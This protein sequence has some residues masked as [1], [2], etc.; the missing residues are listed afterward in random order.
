MFDLYNYN[1]TVSL[2]FK[3]IQKTV[4][5]KKS[6]K[7]QIKTI[8]KVIGELIC[9]ITGWDKD[10]PAVQAWFTGFLSRPEFKK[11]AE[12]VCKGGDTSVLKASLTK[13]PVPPRAPETPGDNK[14]QQVQKQ[15]S[16]PKEEVSVRNIYYKHSKTRKLHT[17]IS[18]FI[19]QCVFYT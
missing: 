1:L 18:K 14:K 9:L 2:S 17:T 6:L 5:L 7:H 3:N 13:Q 10:Y 16:K 8:Y 4:S 11:A 19:V 12:T 15:T